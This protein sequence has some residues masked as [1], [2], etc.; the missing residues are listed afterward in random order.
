MGVVIYA[1]GDSKVGGM[2]LATDETGSRKFSIRKLLV[3]EPPKKIN[4]LTDVYL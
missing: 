2:S 4:C 3:T 1:L